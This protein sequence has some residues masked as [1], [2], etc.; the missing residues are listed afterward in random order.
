M[1]S[2]RSV[3]H[4]VSID[5]CPCISRVTNV[6]PKTATLWMHKIC[7][8]VGSEFQD[9][10]DMQDDSTAVEQHTD[11]AFI[12]YIK[13]EIPDLNVGYMSKQGH[14]KLKVTISRKQLERRTTLNHVK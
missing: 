11:P 13:G 3:L 2:E 7:A 8:Y 14:K 10:S 6:L 12:A 5:S 1:K 4:N 9:L